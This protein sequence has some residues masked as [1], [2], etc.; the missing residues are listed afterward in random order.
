MNA[1]YLAILHQTKND[2]K[3]GLDDL[4]RIIDRKKQEYI[5]IS[6]QILLFDKGLEEISPQ[7]IDCVNGPWDEDE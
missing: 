6:T 2:I 4:R 5:N 3:Q 7:T 1:E